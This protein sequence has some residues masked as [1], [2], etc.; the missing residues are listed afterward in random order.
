MPDDKNAHANQANGAAK[1]QRT[2]TTLSV[3]GV[4]YV[5]APDGSGR[6][7]VLVGA[8]VGWVRHEGIAQWQ[9]EVSVALK[10][11]L[12]EETRA[13]LGVRLPEAGI[14][15]NRHPHAA[16]AAAACTLVALDRGLIEKV[17][18]RGVRVHTVGFDRISQGFFYL[19][20]GGSA[21]PVRVEGDIIAMVAA[22]LGAENTNAD[23]EAA[24]DGL[25]DRLLTELSE[26]VLSEAQVE[27]AAAL[28]HVSNGGDA[29]SQLSAIDALEA[30]LAEG[31]A[32]A[33]RLEDK[34]KSLVG[35][36]GA[37]T[38]RGEETVDV[39][40]YRRARRQ[41]QRELDVDVSYGGDLKRLTLPARTRWYVE[42]PL[43]LDEAPA[44]KVA[45]KPQVAAQAAAHAAAP[46]TT[47][48]PTPAVQ[49]AAAKAQPT[50]EPAAAKAQPTP[51]PAAAKAQPSPQPSPQPTPQP[52]AAKAATATAT[53]TKS[54]SPQPAAVKPA[55]ASKPVEA[56]PVVEV[57]AALRASAPPRPTSGTASP[58][59]PK[60][61][62]TP[63]ASVGEPTASTA[64]ASVPSTPS[65]AEVPAPA[66]AAA[67]PVLESAPLE[68]PV[69]LAKPKVTSETPVPEPAPAVAAKVEEAPAAKAQEAPA[70]KPEE[71]PK[72][73]EAKRDAPAPAKTK[74]AE[75]AQAA[76]PATTKAIAKK[77]PESAAKR[78]EAAPPAEVPK[79][80]GGGMAIVFLVVV[81]V[82]LAVFYVLK[83]R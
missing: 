26:G 16:K 6:A 22:S 35:T 46:A 23:I 15:A 34:A 10:S 50:P 7:L 28:P 20:E 59:G 1:A 75:V 72:P 13:A 73:V 83:M 82:A 8:G 58:P 29:A 9:S 42:G 27:L 61:E 3:P 80:G 63:I 78:A 5:G 37:A 40:L 24:V 14:D 17:T 68:E 2:E 52:A 71:A 56:K 60:V 66:A 62:P 57:P 32:R 76:A 38:R 74:T 25:I 11:D 67:P 12:T 33:T 49:P 41:E 39:P 43:V 69:P 45:E 44:P 18:A 65:A 48:K 55:A 36:L 64:R 81:A 79:K 53:T 54:P 4:V 31:A 47:E 77:G 21:P 51:E 30:E 19:A 70:A